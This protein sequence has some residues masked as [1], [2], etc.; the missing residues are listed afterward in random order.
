M[1]VITLRFEGST[2]RC[3]DP[4]V[5]LA[6]FALSLL[7]VPAFASAQTATYRGPHP[8]DLEGRWHEVDGPHEH[9][10]L[11]VGSEPFGD[12]GGV[13]L[14]LADPLAYGWDGAVWT[15]RGAHP[16]PGGIE[17][18]CGLS[19]DHRHPWAPEGAFRVT[20][21]RVHV[22]RGALRGGLP[23]ARP[24]RTEPREEVVAPPAIASPAPY[25]FWGCRYRLLPG[26]R[27]SFVPTPLGSHCTPRV[28]PGGGAMRS[29]RRAPPS[30]S[31]RR[32]SGGSWFDGN[33]NHTEGRDGVR[34]ERSPS[35]T[36]ED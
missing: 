18:Y 10:E 12:A 22:Y 26:A 19:G 3:Y 20:R 29:G 28:H 31:G 30:G 2:R 21:D 11:V 27:G 9:G 6:L 25:W 1:V 16:L 33:Y 13:R 32:S 35:S 14:F 34:G 24:E 5:R 7:A 4:H 36:Q 23:M 8:V 17:G 15:Y